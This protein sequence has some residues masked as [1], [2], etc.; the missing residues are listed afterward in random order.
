MAMS[1]GYPRLGNPAITP[2]NSLILSKPDHAHICTITDHARCLD[3]RI[4]TSGGFQFLGEKLVTWMSKKEDCTAMS[5][6]KAEYVVLS[7][8]CAQIMWMR[9]HVKDYGFDNNKI[10]LYCYSQSAIAI[11]CNPVQHSRTKHIN[12]CYHFIKEQVRY[13]YLVRRLGMKCLTLAELEVLVN[14]YA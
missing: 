5:I 11:S 2:K 9:T 7:A 4:S 1:S 14:E 12:V 6:A 3:T 10:P 13:E 8:S